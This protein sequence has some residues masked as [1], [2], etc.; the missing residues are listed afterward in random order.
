MNPEETEKWV[1]SAKSAMSLCG[2]F[3]DKEIS[4]SERTALQDLERGGLC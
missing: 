1:E 2:D 4:D 3:W